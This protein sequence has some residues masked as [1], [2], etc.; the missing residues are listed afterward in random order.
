[1]PMHQELR[2]LAALATD[3]ADQMARDDAVASDPGAA[4]GTEQRAASLAV[5]LAEMQAMLQL[6]P[7]GRPLP[8][9]APSA[10]PLRKA[11][12]TDA[13]VEAGFDNMPV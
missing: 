5:L 1:M 11:A 2:R 4:V 3:A 13:D 12:Q 9:A 6:L 7:V 8:D 10:A